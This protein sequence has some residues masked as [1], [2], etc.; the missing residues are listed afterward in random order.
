MKE[1]SEGLPKYDWPGNVREPEHAIGR[2]VPG[3]G[4]VVLLEDLP[5][6]ALEAGWTSSGEPAKYRH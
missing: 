2:A 6:M 1:L 5:E 3:S 4:N